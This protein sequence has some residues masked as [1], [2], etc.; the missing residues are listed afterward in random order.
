MPPSAVAVPTPPEAEPAAAKRAAAEPA[1]VEPAPVEP[2]PVEPPPLTPLPEGEPGNP[3][4]ARLL[5]SARR[6]LRERLPQKALKLLEE[7]AALAGDHPGIQRLLAQT[8]VEARRAEIESL[9]TAALDAFVQNK[10]RKARTA[11]EKALALDPKNRKAQEL[12]KIL[13]SLG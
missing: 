3:D 5:E 4:A 6:Q 8:R 10:H 13:G 1:P 9:T 7:A 2:A 12:L 11:V